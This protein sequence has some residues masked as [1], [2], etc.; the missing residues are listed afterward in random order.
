VGCAVRAVVAVDGLARVTVIR[1]RLQAS[2]CDLKS[3]LGDNLVEGVGAA[4]ELLAGIAVAEDMALLVRLELR[5]P[6]GLPAMAAS[7]VSLR[8]YICF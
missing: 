5:R 3:G 8:H 6:F 2:L 7:S 4:A 1:V